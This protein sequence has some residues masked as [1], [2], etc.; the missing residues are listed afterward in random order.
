M[1]ILYNV[2]PI[3]TKDIPYIDVL[4]ESINN[5]IRLLIG[6]LVVEADV[7]PPASIIFGYWMGGAFL[8]GIKRFAEFRMINDH[9]LAGRYRLSFK[10]YSERTLLVSSFFY[11]MLSVLFTGVFM[12]KYRIELLILIPF[13]CGLF[14]LYLNLSYKKDSAAQRPEKLYREKGLMLY[15]L[16]FITLFVLLMIIN[17]PGLRW[18]LENTLI[19]IH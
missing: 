14:C 5:A 19:S 17:I 13:L 3:R 15:V 10:F 8:M 9:Q 18:F 1:G 2:K 12:I 11:A 4:S 7:L 16:F 6:W